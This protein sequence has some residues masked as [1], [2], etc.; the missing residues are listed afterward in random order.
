M[1]IWG[2]IIGEMINA[3]TKPFPL[4]FPLTIPNEA[5]VPTIV[6]SMVVKAAT[7][8]LSNVGVSHSSLAKKTLYHLN[9]NPSGGKRRKSDALKDMGMTIR[10]GKTR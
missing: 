9:E 2:M 7:F 1:M 8:R 6:E 4:K 5:R 10:K 3:W